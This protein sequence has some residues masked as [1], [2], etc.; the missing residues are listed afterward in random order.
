MT[1]VMTGFQVGYERF[2]RSVAK[3][4]RDMY[5]RISCKE[6]LD[7]IEFDHILLGEKCDRLKEFY[8]ILS[9]TEH[10]MGL[11][12]IRAAGEGD[13]EWFSKM[14]GMSNHV[15]IH[16]PYNSSALCCAIINGRIDIIQLLLKNGTEPEIRKVKFGTPVT[17]PMEWALEGGRPEIISLLRLYGAQIEGERV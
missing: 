3:D 5:R 9:E 1:G 17:S 16:Y 8:P 10:I 13:Y 4:D 11:R 2:L 15:K 12:V 6:D 14:V 7:G